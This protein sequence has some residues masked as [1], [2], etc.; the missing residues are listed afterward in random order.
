MPDGKTPPLA[1]AAQAPKVTGLPV[2]FRAQHKRGVARKAAFVGV[3][4]QLRPGAK[5][6]GGGIAAD[7][8]V[9]TH[10][11]NFVVESRQDPGVWVI[12]RMQFDAP[13]TVGRS[14]QFGTA[15]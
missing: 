12:S 7:N 9:N 1:V 3:A 4:S 8:R 5:F 13:Y 2:N 11:Q 14:A 6:E 15:D 10:H